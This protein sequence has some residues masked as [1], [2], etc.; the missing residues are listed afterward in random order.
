MLWQR[1][2]L[3]EH[4]LDCTIMYKRKDCHMADSCILVVF[5]DVYYYLLNKCFAKCSTISKTCFIRCFM[6]DQWSCCKYSTVSLAL[7]FPCIHPFAASPA[8]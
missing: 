5:R 2:G 6:A 4:L 7:S 8:I 3:P 1:C